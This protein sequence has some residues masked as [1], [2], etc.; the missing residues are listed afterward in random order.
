MDFK[1]GRTGNEEFS[2]LGGTFFFLKRKE[3]KEGKF[4]DSRGPKNYF[5]ILG[6]SILLE[7][8]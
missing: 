7:S 5:V 3:F 6:T 8:N 4:N 1:F 2:I